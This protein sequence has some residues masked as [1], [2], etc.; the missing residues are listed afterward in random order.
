KRW[1]DARTL[2][3]RL[4][5]QFPRF[6]GTPPALSLLASAAGQNEQWALSRDMYAKLGERFPGSSTSAG[7]RLDYAEAL[8]RTGGA[9]GGRR[10]LATTA[11]A[12]AGPNPGRPAARTGRRQSPSA[13]ASMLLAEAQ[14]ATGDRAAA[15]DTYTR[16]AAAGTAKEKAWGPPGQGPP[17]RAA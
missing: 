12:G 15:L 10:T 8:L 14:E 6:E 3:L 7:N 11:A 2:T 17:P 5:D 9:A 4:A 16:V 1:N 13:R